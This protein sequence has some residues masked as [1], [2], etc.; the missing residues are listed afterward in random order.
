MASQVSFDKTNTNLNS[1][2]VQDSID[3]IAD[4][5]S[6]GDAE[7]GDIA[8]GKTA[9]VKGKKIIGNATLTKKEDFGWSYLAWEYYK[10]L[11]TLYTYT[12]PKDGKIL[13]DYFFTMY[14]SKHATGSLHEYLI[15][16]DNI[17]DHATYTNRDSGKT[18]HIKT[19]KQLEITV[20]NGD[21]LYIKA[22]AVD[23]SIYSSVYI[24]GTYI[25]Y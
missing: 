25:S 23:V 15:L 5:L 7:A 22:L 24:S 10:S 8:S 13:L 17:I 18:I 12:V 1:E 6:Y 19:A 20:N 11:T 14:T 21:K 4:I 16:N 2:N 9:L 3:E